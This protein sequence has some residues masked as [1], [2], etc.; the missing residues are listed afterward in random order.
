MQHKKK[1]DRKI[2]IAQHTKNTILELLNTTIHYLFLIL[3]FIKMKNVCKLMLLLFTIPS[4][5]QDIKECNVYPSNIE[6][7]MWFEKYD[8]ATNTIKNINFLVLSDGNNSKDVTPAFTVKL[9][10][11][12]KDKE[13]IYIQT[14]ELEGQ[15]H[16]GSREYKNVNISLA[17][18]T[19]PPGVYRLGVHVNADLSFKEEESD[20]AMLFNGNIV[21]GGAKTAAPKTNTS[22]EGEE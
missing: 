13:P 21:I 14:Y 7:N 8:A 9:Y 1:P 22:E 10:L 16:M 20:N 12:Q 19:I 11:Y 17:A 2:N 4:Y 3:T 6:E 5:A 15:Y 18:F